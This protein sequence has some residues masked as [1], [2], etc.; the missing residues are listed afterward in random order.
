MRRPTE[1]LIDSDRAI[2]IG[3]PAVL[4]WFLVLCVLLMVGNA[5]SDATLRRVD[6]D[7]VR[8]SRV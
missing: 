4:G 7:S 6:G 1:S 3:V 5:L 2:A 8:V